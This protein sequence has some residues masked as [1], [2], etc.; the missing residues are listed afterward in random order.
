MAGDEGETV[1]S[2]V[3][4]PQEVTNN[5]TTNIQLNTTKYNY[6]Q[7]NLYNGPNTAIRTL[8]LMLKSTKRR[9]LKE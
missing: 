2:G 4:F 7:L 8:L 9:Q 1:E 6:I 3:C 5:C